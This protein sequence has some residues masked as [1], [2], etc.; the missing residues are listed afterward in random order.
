M[1]SGRGRKIIYSMVIEEVATEVQEELSGSVKPCSVQGNA[2]TLDR[3]GS[4]VH[5]ALLSLEN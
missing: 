4:M 3:L 2:G 5:P 1:Q